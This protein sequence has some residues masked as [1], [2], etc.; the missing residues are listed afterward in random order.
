MDEV[1]VAFN[2]SLSVDKILYQVDVDASIAYAKALRK[3]DLLSVHELSEITQGLEAVATEWREG[4]F[5]IKPSVDEDIHTANERRLGELVGAQIAGK[6]H[7]GRSRNEQI[8]VDLRLWL[9]AQLDELRGI[10]Q[11]LLTTFAKRA[12]AEVDVLISGYTHLQPAQA[13]RWS[14]W[15]LY[16]ATMLQKDL[17]KLG[18]VREEVD[19]CPL[20]V[21]ALSGN[22]FA[23]DRAL[24]ARELGFAKCHPNSLACVADRDFIIDTVSWGATLMSHLG[25]LAQDLINYSTKE[26]GFVRVADAY[27]TGSSLMPQKKNPDS[28]ELIRGKAGTVNG[29]VSCLIRYY[30]SDLEDIH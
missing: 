16:H 6:L 27:S 9:R 3:R 1:M 15:L 8:I 11:Q 19:E 29:Y 25:R 4:A 28:L 12:E 23:L 10:L 13:V 30:A 22:P 18:P 7:T 17:R 2:E 26:F 24:M 5:V 21:G 14:H 20:G